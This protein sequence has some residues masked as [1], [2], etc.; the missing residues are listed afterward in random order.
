MFELTKKSAVEVVLSKRFGETDPE[1][2]EN[3]NEINIWYSADNEL[4]EMGICIELKFDNELEE[5][6]QVNPQG[7]VYSWGN[8]PIID[9]RSQQVKLKLENVYKDLDNSDFDD[10]DE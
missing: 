3:L 8:S 2:I 5:N 7:I 1:K 10:D 6:Y 9:E 4:N